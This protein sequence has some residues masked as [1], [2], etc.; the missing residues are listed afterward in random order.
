MTEEERNIMQNVYKITGIDT[1]TQI[2]MLQ[3]E[4]DSEDLLML[5][6]ERVQYKL[7]NREITITNPANL[8]DLMKIE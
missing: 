1:S 5:P 4:N 6:I 7:K 2:V 8:T 3:N